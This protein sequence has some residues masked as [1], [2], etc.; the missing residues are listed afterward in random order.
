MTTRASRMRVCLTPALPTRATST[1]GLQMLAFP[2]PV[3]S[4]PGS[5]TSPSTPSSRGCSR[6]NG[7]ATDGGTCFE[8]VVDNAM[9]VPNSGAFQLCF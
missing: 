9:G 1:V 3:R 2:M 4:T 6:S 5:R 7:G 8:G